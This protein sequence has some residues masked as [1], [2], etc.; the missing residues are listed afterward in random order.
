M[1]AGRPGI[2]A[3]VL[4]RMCEH[5]SDRERVAVEAE[6]ASLALKKVMYAVDHVGD[7]FEGV[8]SSVSRFG[9]YI[10]LTDLLV[11]GMV[12]VRDM[13]DDYYEY[14]ERKFSLVGY[15]NGRRYRPGDSVRVTLVAARLESREIDL[16]FSEQKDVRRKR[17]K[18][19]KH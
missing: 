18:R 15:Q 16:Q 5:A 10:E 4:K 19:R 3:A 13:T 17:K 7:E 12:H 8:V 14:D 1:N 6:R 2:D 11:E 9:V